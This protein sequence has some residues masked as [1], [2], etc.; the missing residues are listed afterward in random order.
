MD[1]QK[2]IQIDEWKYL[3]KNKKKKLSIIPMI[4]RNDDRNRNL[5]DK[6]HEVN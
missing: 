1:R 3:E 6:Q 5:I 2:V 4:F